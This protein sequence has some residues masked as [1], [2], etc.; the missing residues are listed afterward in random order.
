MFAKIDGVENLTPKQK[1]RLQG[2]VREFQE[3][4]SDKPGRTHLV[5]HNIELT[6][7]IPVTS[8]PYR[9]SPRQRE[10]MNAQINRMIELGGIEVG[11]SDYA[12]PFILIEGPG[13]EPILYID[14]RKLNSITRDQTHPIPNIEG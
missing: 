10:I 11:E 9:V 14:Y 1:E 12:S 2:L 13:K 8:R 5:V 7:D 6:N 4:L 3:A